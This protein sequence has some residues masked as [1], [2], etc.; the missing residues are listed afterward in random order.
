MRPPKIQPLEIDPHLQARLGVLAEKQGASLADFTES[1]LRSYTDESERTI[2]EQAED[3]GRWQRYLE[4]GVSVPFE[5]VR[6]RLRGFAAE[7]RR[8]LEG[9]EGDG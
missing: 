1:V 2:S 4:T 6:A 3:E 9:T 5:T 8:T 7:A